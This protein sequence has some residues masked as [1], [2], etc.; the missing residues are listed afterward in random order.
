MGPFQSWALGGRT[1]SP[2]V[3]SGP[4][5]SFFF[6][7]IVVEELVL[8]HIW[9][10]W[11]CLF[12]RLCSSTARSSFEASDVNINGARRELGTR[13]AAVQ[14]DLWYEQHEMVQARFCFTTLR[15]QCHGRECEAIYGERNV[16]VLS[17]GS[18]PLEGRMKQ[19]KILLV[20]NGAW[21]F[22]LVCFCALLPTR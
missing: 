20:V 5:G 4:D 17:C 1:G 21:S 15:C 12:G 8:I 14:Y 2:R 22:A 16:C 10:T 9:E 6:Y 11:S 19:A 13:R 3:R 7:G 18:D